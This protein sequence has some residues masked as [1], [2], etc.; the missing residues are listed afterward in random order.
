VT[1]LLGGGAE[2]VSGN[3]AFT[4]NKPSTAGPGGSWVTHGSI[5]ATIVRAYAICTT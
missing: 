2:I 5:G 4:Y 1:V 3:G